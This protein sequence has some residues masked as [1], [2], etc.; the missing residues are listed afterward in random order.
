MRCPKCDHEQ[1]YP[2]HGMHCAK[3]RYSVHLA[4]DHAGV[5]VLYWTQAA[6][7]LVFASEVR[8]LLAAPG[9][10]PRL[11]AAGLV[12]YLT[13]SFDPGGSSCTPSSMVPAPGTKLNV[14][15]NLVLEGETFRWDTNP[16]RRPPRRPPNE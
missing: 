9:V 12:E 13:F 11:R 10:A 2:K 7:L 4:R 3:C 14:R 1:R 5:K 16:A 15:R 6:G 8:A